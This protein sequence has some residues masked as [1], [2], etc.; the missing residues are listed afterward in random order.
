[1]IDGEGKAVE[2]KEVTPYLISAL[3]WA[4]ISVRLIFPLPKLEIEYG[5]ASTFIQNLRAMKFI[6]TVH[7]VTCSFSFSYVLQCFNEFV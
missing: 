7:A 2:R 5:T 4:Q 1:M 3:Q 6:L